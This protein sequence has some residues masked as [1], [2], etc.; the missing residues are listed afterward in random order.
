MT[1]AR[2]IRPRFDTLGRIT[3]AIG[4]A[5]AWLCAVPLAAQAQELERRPSVDRVVDAFV[6]IQ[7]FGL[8]RA[9]PDGRYLVVEVTRPRATRARSGDAPWMN[10]TDLW[11]VDLT[12][13]KT[14][15][16][17]SGAD[18]GDAAWEPI[19]SPDSRRIAYLTNARDGLPRAAWMDVRTR[20][21]GLLTERGVDIEV[22]FGA[23]GPFGEDRRF[24]GAWIGEDHF[25]MAASAPGEIVAQAR[26]TA[27]EL[28]T[29]PRWAAR[30]EGRA[31]VTIWD[32]ATQPQ[33]STTTSLLSFE[34]GSRGRPRELM[35]GPVRAVTLSPNQDQAAVV[36]ATGTLAPPRLGVFDPEMNYYNLD[37]RVHTQLAL[38]G[39]R[40]NGAGVVATDAREVRFQSSL[41][42]PRWTSDSD[43]LFAPRRQIVEGAAGPYCVEGLRASGERPAEWRID[44]TR[45]RSRAH[46][47]L[48]ALSLSTAAP[49]SL[50]ELNA[51]IESTSRATSVA[52]QPLGDDSAPF[53]LGGV[54]VGL[55]GSNLIRLI[56][57]RS[58]EIVDE[59]EAED[60]SLMY[61]LAP[62]SGAEAAVLNI[63]GVRQIVRV[64]QNRL[65]LMAVDAP[66]E[67][68][69][70]MG[71]VAHS[72]AL[73]WSSDDVQGRSL[74]LSD[75]DG[76]NWRQLMRLDRPF[77][78]E[79]HLERRALHYRLPDGRDAVAILLL[80]PNYDPSRPYPMILDVYPNMPFTDSS[81]QR[82]FDPMSVYNVEA[83]TFAHMGYI[84]AKPSTLPYEGDP[85]DYEALNYF[86]GLVEAFAQEALARGMTEPGRIGLWG[87][88]NGGYLGLG[89]AGRTR[90]I[91]A[92]VSYSPFPD[93]IQVSELPAPLFQIDACAPNRLYG[94]SMPFAED[95]N[96]PLW[97]IGG[98]TSEALDRYIRSSPIYQLGP[99]TP[100]LLLIQGE[101]DGRGT[102]DA[103]R[104]YTR[105]NRQ[106]VPVQLVRYWGE[107]H[108]FLVAES[109]R[110]RVHRAMNW[111]GAHLRDAPSD[112]SAAA[113]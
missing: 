56:D 22:N 110:D 15:Q 67:A 63:A 10:L 50:D 109:I 29:P 97:R 80:P 14:R 55:T 35:T 9:S 64:A 98:Q 102:A 8:V 5:F 40:A 69:T 36:L 87:H 3:R 93:L 76:R 31:P 39:L 68:V 113:P 34:V 26:M 11:L 84:V 33:C 81:V 95:P 44:C 106:N 53:S 91:N 99:Q 30:R 16:L 92:I 73:V 47:R 20:R 70:P 83:Y 104:V 85:A 96:G 25:L 59:V 18:T 89:A 32:S 101:F 82:Q 45:V 52:G 60:L 111:F 58:G 49:H 107:G 62:N 75:A 19:W 38:I 12:D 72:E 66:A 46:A 27:P 103:Q 94:G 54:Y 42:A 61:S 90:L 51:R 28:V 17:T 41:D 74:W 57:L 24:W 48:L 100:P 105:L 1:I 43:A 2:H 6:S 112:D 79:L 23:R 21:G 7:E 13:G 65:S 77:P 37:P 108:N 86:A 4:V 71:L 88:S 78:T